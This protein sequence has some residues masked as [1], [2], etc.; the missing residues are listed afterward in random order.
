MT[1]KRVFTYGTKLDALLVALSC[2]TSIGSGI[3]LPLMNIVLGNAHQ[4]Y[5]PPED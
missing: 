3:A 2:L 1:C 4:S 5:L